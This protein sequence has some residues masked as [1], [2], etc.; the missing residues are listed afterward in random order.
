MKL[1]LLIITFFITAIAASTLIG[2]KGYVL[3]ALG[4]LRIEST[5]VGFIFMAIA[6]VLASWLLIKLVKQLVRLG[7]LSWI[8]LAF[9]S[10]ARANAKF[11]QGLLRFA[12]ADYQRCEQ[13]MAQ[14]ADRC[15]KPA[16]AWLYAAA[17][18]QQQQNKQQSRYYLAAFLQHKAELS[19][20]DVVV[21]LTLYLAQSAY[22]DAE[23]LLDKH[24]QLIGHD[25]QLL[26]LAI[27]LYLHQKRYSLVADLLSTASKLIDDESRLSQWLFDCY[28][29]WFEQ[30][31]TEQDSQAVQNKWQQL[32]K[33][34]K[35][36]PAVMLAY[37][38]VMSAHK[39]TGDWYDS[40]I[41]CLKKQP[42]P[43]FLHTLQRV[44]LDD[45]DRI[46]AF[47]QQQLKKTPDSEQWLRLLAHLSANNQQ[48]DLALKAFT[49][50]AEQLQKSQLM[51]TE[52]KQCYAKVLMH[53]AQFEAAAK[54]LVKEG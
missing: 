2:D 14:C 50:L 9:A 45:I 31:I 29:Q 22:S 10:K 34:V 38:Q 1:L 17:S 8:K 15:D 52:D 18:A 48:W 36:Q 54:L 41:N 37:A 13:L 19:V 49:K 51:S 28:S 47:I 16:I 11:E 23:K 43:W 20:N 33:K 40:V 12:A 3:I 32:P 44:S 42:S 46:I 53:L 26:G 27:E 5:V 30:L 39:L 6:L 24:H 35:R 21:L 25:A 7:H 4:Q